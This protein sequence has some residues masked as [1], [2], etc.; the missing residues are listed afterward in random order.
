MSRTTS[1]VRTTARVAAAVV[2]ASAVAI[3][4]P[5]AIPAAATASG[6]VQLGHSPAST[7]ATSGASAVSP[8]ALPRTDARTVRVA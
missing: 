2:S 4:G 3:V 8:T 6:A 1:T 5:A 7:Y